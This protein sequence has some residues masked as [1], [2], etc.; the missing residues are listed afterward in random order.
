[1]ALDEDR[2]RPGKLGDGTPYALYVPATCDGRRASE[3]V[4]S[5][6]P[7]E[8]SVPVH[9]DLELFADFATAHR[10]VVLAPRFDFHGGFQRLGI[11]T[12]VRHDLR[13]LEMVD[14]AARSQPIETRRF[15]LFGYSAGGQFAHRFLY[16]HR[17]RLG[18]VAIGAPGTVTLPSLAHGWP[19]GVADLEA[20]AGKRRDLSD[21]QWPRILLFVGGQ[22]VGDEGVNREDWANRTGLTRLERART[23]HAAFQAAAIEHEYVE[24][25]AM[26]HDDIVTMEPVWRFLAGGAGTGDRQP[27]A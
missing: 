10:C 16:L 8:P 26:G 14:D 6:L 11:G 4:V 25:P 23:L 2:I 9:R 1:M 13:L 15:H 5:V 3:L 17:E 27:G 19:A 7:V 20:V 21:R 22:D 24:V 12:A 18:A